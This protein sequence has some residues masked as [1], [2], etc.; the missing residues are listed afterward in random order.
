MGN[1]VQNCT[2]LGLGIIVSTRRMGTV[3]GLSTTGKNM[4]TTILARTREYMASEYLVTGK[5]S[6][7]L[8]VYSFGIVALKIACG[9]R[10]IDQ[11]VEES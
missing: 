1:K 7:E 8:D 4:R 2:R 11:N 3:R 10:P 9:R 6:K 5:A